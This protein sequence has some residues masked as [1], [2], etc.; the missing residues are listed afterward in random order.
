VPLGGQS[1]VTGENGLSVSLMLISA[2]RLGDCHGHGAP[3]RRPQAVCGGHSGGGMFPSRHSC[4]PSHVADSLLTSAGGAAAR[5][6]ALLADEL[7]STPAAEQGRLLHAAVDM[8]AGFS[9]AIRRCDV[10]QR[11]HSSVMVRRKGGSQSSWCFVTMVVCFQ[12]DPG[13]P[14]RSA[15][16]GR[17][18]A[19]ERER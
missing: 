5:S 17:R 7:W 4:A 18:L 10:A 2:D 16:A 13:S 8:T 1:E 15:H 3:S 6:V 9:A 19:E 12:R 11:C 14:S